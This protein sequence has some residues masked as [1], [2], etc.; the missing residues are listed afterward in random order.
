MMNHVI[1]KIIWFVAFVVFCAVVTGY[2]IHRDIEWL[3]NNTIL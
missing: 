1:A 3:R 2:G